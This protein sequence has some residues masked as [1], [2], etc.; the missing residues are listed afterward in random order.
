[1][2]SAHRWPSISVQIELS[3][4]LKLNTFC[5][6]SFNWFFP[7]YSV[8]LLLHTRQHMKWLLTWT[9]AVSCDHS[10][11][12]F[13]MNTRWIKLGESEKSLSDLNG[14]PEMFTCQVNGA[15]NAALANIKW[16]WMCRSIDKT[17]TCKVSKR[18]KQRFVFAKIHWNHL[19]MLWWQ[20]CE[21]SHVSNA[22]E[23]ASN[24]H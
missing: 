9:N 24:R 6:A 5:L 10:L 11:S 2:I 20:L 4:W 12:L 16:Q 19:A 22:N 15:Q 1:M 18:R 3:V 14:I 13:K 23:L 17:L 8:L 7:L 21:T